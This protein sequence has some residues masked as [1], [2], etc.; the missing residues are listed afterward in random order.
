[1]VYERLG[2][3]HMRQRIAKLIRLGPLH[4]DRSFADDGSTMPSGACGLQVAENAFQ[5]PSLKET[6]GLGRQAKAALIALQAL[7]LRQFPNVVFNEVPQGL[8]LLNIAWLGEL[9]QSV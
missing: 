1:S 7:S 6:I 9:R 5:K 8:E 4:F 2:N 3:V